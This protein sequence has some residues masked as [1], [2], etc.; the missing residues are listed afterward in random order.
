MLK[1]VTTLGGSPLIKNT[2]YLWQIGIQKEQRMKTGIIYSVSLY[3]EG[4]WFERTG[5]DTKVGATKTSGGT[6]VR[7]KILLGILMFLV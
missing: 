7:Q 1:Y 6:P 3:N 4:W 2:W 5:R